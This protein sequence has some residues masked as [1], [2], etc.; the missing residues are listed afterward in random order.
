MADP[1]THGIIMIGRL[2][3]VWK[4]MQL[5]G[6]KRMVRS[7]MEAGFIVGQTA[8]KVVKWVAGAIIGSAADTA[9]AK[10]EHHG[11]LWYNCS[12]NASEIGETMRSL[13]K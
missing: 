11:G 7:C 5:I 6:L 3:A 12:K 13:M 8:P 4:Q 1:D 9:E 10:D 2:V